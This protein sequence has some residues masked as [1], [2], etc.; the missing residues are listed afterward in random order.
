MYQLNELNIRRKE[1]KLE[2]KK[3]EEAKEKINETHTFSTR[4]NNNR[5]NKK[6]R[7][8]NEWHGP[9]NKEQKNVNM[10]TKFC[11]KL[12]PHRPGVPAP[13]TSGSNSNHTHTKMNWRY[14]TRNRYNYTYIHTYIHNYLLTTFAFCSVAQ[15]LHHYHWFL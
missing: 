13:F 9:H 11:Y 5:N 10:S 14:D 6:V 3:K 4:D 7:V 8:R 2:W 1:G 15:H 12:G